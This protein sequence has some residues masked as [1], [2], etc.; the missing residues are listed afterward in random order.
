MMFVNQRYR[1][2]KGCVNLSFIKNKWQHNQDNINEFFVQNIS[3]LA[4]PI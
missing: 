1:F 2:L 3:L 4:E